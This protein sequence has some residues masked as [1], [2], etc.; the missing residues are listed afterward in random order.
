MNTISI[1]SKLIFELCSAVAPFMYSLNSTEDFEAFMAELGW[2]FSFIPTPFSNMSSSASIILSSLSNIEIDEEEILSLSVELEK[3]FNILFSFNEAPNN[4]FP[5]SI[6]VDEFKE[7]F[8]RQIF[9]NLLYEYL[10][11]SK[12]KLASAFQLLGFLDFEVI[13]NI[14]KRLAYHKKGVSWERL[15]HFF[16]EP[17][18]VI[19]QTYN[20]EQDFN[21]GLLIKNFINVA[22]SFGYEINFSNLD[23]KI[24]NSLFNANDS[25]NITNSRLYQLPLLE[26]FIGL[27][28]YEAGVGYY[29]LSQNETDKPGFAILPYIMGDA[30][31]EAE[32]DDDVFLEI[33]G[34][35]DVSK[36]VCVQVRPNKPIEI[37]TDIIPAEENGIEPNQIGSI[38]FGVNNKSKVNNKLIVIGE[39]EASRF[40]VGAISLFAGALIESLNDDFFI[41]VSIS[42]AAIVL[43][44]EPKTD[45][46]INSLL[47]PNGLKNEFDLIV[48]L[49]TKRGLY[50]RGSSRLEVIIPIHISVFESLSIDLAH[51]Q[52]TTDND[53]LK[54]TTALSMG[55]RFGPVEFSIQQVGVNG[56]ISISDGNSNFGMINAQYEFKSPAG[57]GLSIDGGGFKGGGFLSFEEDEQRYAGFLELEFKGTIN[58]KAIGLLTTQLP[59]GNDGYSF[60]II[61]TAEFTPIQLGFGFTLNGVGGLLGLNRSANIERLRTGVKDN[62]LSSILFPQ[63]IVENASRIISDLRQVFPPTKDRFIFGPMLKIGWGTPTL[64]SIDVGLMIEVPSPVRLYILGVARVRLP[65]EADSGE[66]VPSLLTLQVNFLGVVDFDAQNLSFDASLYDSK[67]LT[68]ILSGDMA[69]RFSW[70]DEPNFLMS[71]GGFHPSYEPPPLALPKMQRLTVSLLEG[72]NPR[73]SMETYYAVT[74]N[75]IQYGARIEL[76]VVKSKFNVSGFLSFDVLFQLNPFYFIADIGAMLSLNIG[77][78]N[79]ASIFL[80]LTLD[81]PTP[82][83]VKGTAKLKICWFFTLKVPFNKTFGNEQA[84]RLDDVAVLPLLQAALSNKGNWE[85]TISSGKKALVSVKEVDVGDNAIIVDPQGVL[86]INQKVVPLNT[87]I[88]KF[89]SQLPTDGNVFKIEKVFVGSD[90]EEFETTTLQESFAPAQFFEKTDAE[91]LSSKSF[92]RFESG[93]NLVQSEKFS[94]NYTALRSVEYELFYS[95]EQRNQRIR[96][97]PGLFNPDGLVFNALASKGALA[98]SPLSYENKPKSSLA[99]DAV[100]MKGEHFAVVNVNDMQ[101]VNTDAIVENETSAYL[102]MDK[103]LA[104][105]PELEGEIQVVPTYEMNGVI[106]L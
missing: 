24:Q 23:N 101:E 26:T 64:I 50:F 29:P 67:L 46:F 49:S 93:V 20:W 35:F 5:D 102:M 104:S 95:D 97:K 43:K 73:I 22:E 91:K 79:I 105:H 1:K 17:F 6:D 57:I 82:W 106:G 55:V 78:S 56:S 76:Y 84:T 72:D 89:G 44:P 7:E 30:S 45:S 58:L 66:D 90:A 63:N 52:I 98:D 80:S 21:S 19:K 42:D 70:G 62:T 3:V 4:L 77:N 81:G 75:T 94:A 103:I 47:E 88:Q 74:S 53:V 33:K 69:V 100:K 38:S 48:G 8:P 10:Y 34:D 12:P 2:D 9:N 15:I 83:H 39:K 28:D 86:S 54:L 37:I 96:R 32:I 85:T 14:N 36:G 18:S 41:E 71:I 92:E 99:P 51:I 13:P 11:D 68:F 25:Q 31:W 27:P 65:N 61:I 16:K 59:D 40:E 60:L 87:A